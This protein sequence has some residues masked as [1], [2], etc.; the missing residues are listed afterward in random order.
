MPC[1][2]TLSEA[3]SQRG[4]RLAGSCHMKFIVTAI[5]TAV[6]ATAAPALAEQLTWES[7]AKVAIE[8]AEGAFPGDD[9]SRPHMRTWNE[10]ARIARQLLDA[11]ARL[12]AL[13][14]VEELEDVEFAFV[15]LALETEYPTHVRLEVA[16]SE[17]LLAEYIVD[18]TEVDVQLDK[19]AAALDSLGAFNA[20]MDKFL[21]EASVENAHAVD[22]A[23]DRALSAANDITVKH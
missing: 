6:L 23:A 14:R 18:L 20:A 17:A 21:K 16:Q 8:R 9:E 19:L 7:Y 5:V 22:E 4:R 10:Q 3:S 15:V 2:N 11:A 12:E 13:N 1:Y